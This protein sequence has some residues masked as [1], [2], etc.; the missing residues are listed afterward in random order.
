MSDDGPGNT[1]W[2][3]MP[4]TS[5]MAETAC[6]GCGVVLNGSTALDFDATPSPGDVSVCSECQ[7]VSI[8]G[9]D[10]QLR[11]FTREEIDEILAD[12]E[13]ME[14]LTRAVEVLHLVLEAD[15]VRRGRNN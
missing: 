3:L 10:L 2:E 12:D 13:A 8:W 7:A 14:E 1:F 15:D 6:P 5:R 11:G 4:H 9:D